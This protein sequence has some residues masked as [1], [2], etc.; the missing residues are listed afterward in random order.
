MLPVLKRGVEIAMTRKVRVLL[1]VLV[2]CACLIGAAIAFASETFTTKIYFTPDKLGAPANLSATTV[3]ALQGTMVPTPIGHVLAYGPAGLEVDVAGTG[4]CQKALLEEKGP[5]GCPADSRI[6]FGGGLGLVEIA[7][8]FIKEPY[9]LDFFVAP[10]ENGH[11][12]FLIYA[13]GTSP[14][15]VELVIVAK[16]VHGVKPYGIGFEFEIPPIPTL[17][18]AAYA[19]VETNYFTV[20]SQKVA[21]YHTVHG[22]Q[23][24]VHVK[25]LIVPKTCPKGGFPFK[26]TVNFLDGTSAT[27]MYTA[28]CPH[29]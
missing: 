28:P 24:L 18:G 6:G 16:E 26:V 23:K 25:G 29:K 21:Y 22:K 11:L 19:S 10:K 13:Q 7:K 27:D 15:S 4:T 3:F 14:V 8:E 5:S 2:G 20:G 9:T 17:P 1:V 12:T